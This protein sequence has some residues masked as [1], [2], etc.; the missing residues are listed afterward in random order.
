MSNNPSKR[1]GRFNSGSLPKKRT[2]ILG[3]KII[4]TGGEPPIKYPLNTKVPNNV[5]H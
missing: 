3:V 5:K 4:G 1:C 2:G